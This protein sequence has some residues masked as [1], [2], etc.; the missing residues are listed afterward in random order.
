MILRKSSILSATCSCFSPLRFRASES[1]T[2]SQ[3]PPQRPRQQ[4]RVR[5]HQSGYASI[6][7]D[8][9]RRKTPAGTTDAEHHV[10]PPPPNGQPVPTPYQIFALKQDAAYDKARFYELVKIYH[11]DVNGEAGNG[12]SHA[13]KVERYRLV[14]TAHAILSDPARRSAYD[15]FG[16]GWNGK[17]ELGAR[18]TWRQTSPYHPPGPFSHSWN[19]VDSRIWQNATWED[20]ERFRADKARARENGAGVYPERRAP[21]YMANSYFLAV[22]VALAMAGSSLNYGRAQDNGTYLVERRDI[23]HDQS[24][25]NLRNVRKEVSSLSSQQD[26]IDFFVRQREATVG[27]FGGDYEAFREERANRI[28]SDKEFCKSEDV[29]ENGG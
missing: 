20:W 10:W 23:V 12:M 22:I 16:S 13:E 17:A 2:S 9:K 28:L 18:D 1:S 27:E 5:N 4:S 25:K 14:V 7:D 8:A 21:V 19:D 11:P 29:K 3:C 24:A 15:R 26:R 6:A